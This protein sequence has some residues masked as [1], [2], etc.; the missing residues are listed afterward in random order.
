MKAMDDIRIV[1]KEWLL[2]QSATEIDYK[3]L[4]FENEQTKLEIWL[5]NSPI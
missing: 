2:F 1:S 3:T 5:S 4:G